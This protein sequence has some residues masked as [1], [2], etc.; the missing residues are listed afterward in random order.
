[1]PLCHEAGVEAEVDWGEA[2]VVLG[3]VLTKVYLFLM[4]SCFSGA[5]FVVA[6]PRETQRYIVRGAT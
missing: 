2:T 5:C 1:V 4:R 3:G 6:F